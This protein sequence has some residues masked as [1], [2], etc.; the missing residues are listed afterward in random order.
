MVF[1]GGKSVASR[2]SSSCLE[3]PSTQKN[4]YKSP[5]KYVN[6]TPND[7]DKITDCRNDNDMDANMS[8]VSID[9]TQWVSRRQQASR[10]GESPSRRT[11][12]QTSKSNCKVASSF[13]AAISSPTTHD[14]QATSRTSNDRPL[15]IGSSSTSKNDNVLIEGPPSDSPNSD[16]NNGLND[17][18]IN[19]IIEEKLQA[20]LAVLNASFEGKLRRVEMDTN[21]RLEE[22]EIKLKTKLMESEIKKSDNSIIKKKPK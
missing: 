15:A 8:I 16:C 13:L 18:T 12:F 9:E 6:A 4:S 10:Q 20:K 7:G 14:A 17:E 22:M 11:S 2:Y 1:G 3:Y 19:K 5:P 21:A